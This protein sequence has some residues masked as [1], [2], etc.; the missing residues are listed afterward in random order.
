MST[1]DLDWAQK[2]GKTVKKIKE[3]IRTQ[4]RLLRKLRL[5]QPG[6][7]SK[8]PTRSGDSYQEH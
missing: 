7:I 6:N 5:K 2:V 1:L 3:K 8:G 4:G